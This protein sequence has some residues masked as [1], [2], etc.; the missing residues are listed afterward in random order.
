MITDTLDEMLAKLTPEEQE[1]AR[2]DIAMFGKLAL[3]IPVLCSP[4]MFEHARAMARWAG[5]ADACRIHVLEDLR[6]FFMIP[7]DN[8]I[9]DGLLAGRREGRC[10]AGICEWRIV[11]KQRENVMGGE[12]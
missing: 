3:K 7:N 4:D 12:G 6:G 9:V 2:K 10:V 1:T 8:M 5:V 11:T